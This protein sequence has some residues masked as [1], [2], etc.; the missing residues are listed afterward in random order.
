MGFGDGTRGDREGNDRRM[1][2][3]RSERD[4]LGQMRRGVMACDGTTELRQGGMEGCGLVVDV[5]MEGCK[6][7]LVQVVD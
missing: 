4:G 5:P 6:A 2:C 7:A 3:D 1:V